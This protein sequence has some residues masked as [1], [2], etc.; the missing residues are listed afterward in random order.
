MAELRI[1]QKL[2]S[3]AVILAIRDKGET[4]AKVVMALNYRPHEQASPYITWI[5]VP[6]MEDDGAYEMIWGN[7]FDDVWAAASDFQ[8][9]S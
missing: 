4:P 5:A 9:R 7:Y 1:G 2:P 3:G 6:P 8:V